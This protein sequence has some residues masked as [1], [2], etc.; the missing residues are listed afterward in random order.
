M[1]ADTEKEA[2][3]ITEA[4]ERRSAISKAYFTTAKPMDADKI[5]LIPKG[6]QDKYIPRG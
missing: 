2:E 3:Q 4:A 5:T 1:P 6:H